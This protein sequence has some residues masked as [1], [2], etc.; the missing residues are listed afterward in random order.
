M[1]P[2]NQAHGSWACS[3]RLVVRSLLSVPPPLGRLMGYI[4]PIKPNTSQQVDVCIIPCMKPERSPYIL[5]GIAGK[6]RHSAYRVENVAHPRVVHSER[7][8]LG[9][10]KQCLCSELTEVWQSKRHRKLTQAAWMKRAAI[11]CFGC[12]SDYLSIDMYMMCNH[13]VQ[14]NVH[15]KRSA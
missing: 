14:A 8:G 4:S 5:V 15:L 3:V 9:S 11:Y 1:R 7:T 10:L 6:S 13:W 12:L 2:G